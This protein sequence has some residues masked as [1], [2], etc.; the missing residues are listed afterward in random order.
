MNKI[1][2]Q[3]LDK[4]SIDYDLLHSGRVHVGDLIGWDGHIAVIAGL[5]DTEIYVTESLLPGVVLDE[6]DISSPY[7]RFYYRYSYIID[8]SGVYSGDGNMPDMW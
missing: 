5:T 6:Y 3:K 2:F 4:K 8:L 7:S 1:E